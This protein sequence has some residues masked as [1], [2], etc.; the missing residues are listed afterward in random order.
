MLDYF[1]TLSLIF[2]LDFSLDTLAPKQ[3]WDTGEIRYVLLCDLAWVLVIIAM[4]VLFS[5]SLLRFIVAPE[6]NKNSNDLVLALLLWA[7]CFCADLAHFCI[8]LRLYIRYYHN[9]GYHV[10]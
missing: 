1:S 10:L 7:L 9:I 6:Y 5:L 2:Q 4:S 8:L 3:F